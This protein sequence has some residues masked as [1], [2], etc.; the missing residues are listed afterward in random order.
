MWRKVGEIADTTGRIPLW[1]ITF[2]TR[3]RHKLTN[4]RTT[5]SKNK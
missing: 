3:M 2:P 1:L 4:C 5:K